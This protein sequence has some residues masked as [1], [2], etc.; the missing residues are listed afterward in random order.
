M[1]LKYPLLQIKNKKT[2]QN[3]RRNEKQQRKEN[4]GFIF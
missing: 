3:P 4:N 1:T 2:K